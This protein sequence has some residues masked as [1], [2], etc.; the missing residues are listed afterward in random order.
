MAGDTV[1]AITVVVGIMVEAITAVGITAAAIAVAVDITSQAVITRARQTMPWR[2]ATMVRS[3][4][5]VQLELPGRTTESMVAWLCP[6]PVTSATS[7]A[8]TI[9]SAETQRLNYGAVGTG[10]LGSAGARTFNSNFFGVGSN[11]NS[12]YGYGNGRYGY[13]SRGYGY[14]GCGYSNSRY[15]KAFVPGVGWVRVPVW[16]IRRF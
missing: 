12:G 4:V 6:K 11:A 8:R 9:R 7:A 10:S 1:A 13:G 5:T 16:A 14:G 3:I 2:R 15:V